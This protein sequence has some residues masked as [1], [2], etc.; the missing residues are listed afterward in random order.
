MY[1]PKT[2][3]YVYKVGQG[4]WEKQTL[5]KTSEYQGGAKSFSLCTV[6]LKTYITGGVMTSN[7]TPL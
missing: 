6:G 2:E 7:N 1:G 3:V 5:D 4:E